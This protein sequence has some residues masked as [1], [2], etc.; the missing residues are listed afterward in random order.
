MDGMPRVQCGERW[1]TSS[2]ARSESEAV[3]PNSLFPNSQASLNTYA[4]GIVADC[5]IE[6]ERLSMLLCWGSG[7]ALAPEQG[8]VSPGEVQALEQA[9]GWGVSERE[10][11]RDLEMES[12]RVPWLLPVRTYPR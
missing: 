10:R 4:Y 8:P 2:L 12:R 7:W 3:E 1:Q 11:V 6:N 9:L 5:L